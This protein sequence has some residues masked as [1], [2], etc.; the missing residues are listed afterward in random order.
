MKKQYRNFLCAS[1]ILSFTPFSCFYDFFIN[2]LVYSNALELVQD[3]PRL[4]WAGTRQ[5]ASFVKWIDSIIRPQN[6][7]QVKERLATLGVDGLTIT[8]IR[9]YGRQK[10]HS[11]V[12]RGTEY[13]VDFV[14]KVMLTII[15]Q[16]E[17]VDDIVE[18]IMA[19]ARTGKMGD[20]K[21][22]VTALDEVVR[23][24]TGERGNSA[25]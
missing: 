11:E 9:G 25:I 16:D 5:G 10:G 23:I 13:A 15:A 14:P 17:R 21:I 22:I 2:W 1:K 20:G 4:I 6:L 12:Y 3:L 18:A 24:R 7:D 8:E 19:S